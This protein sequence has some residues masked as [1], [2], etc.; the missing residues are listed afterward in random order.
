MAQ[1][2][3]EMRVLSMRHSRSPP[4]VEESSEEAGAVGRKRTA[5]E[6]FSMGAEE[7]GEG[8]WGMEAAAEG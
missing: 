7:D 2:K 3:R 4:N 1:W 8:S 5:T 6:I